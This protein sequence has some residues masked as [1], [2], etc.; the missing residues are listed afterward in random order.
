MEEQVLPEEKLVK[1]RDRQDRNRDRPS[2]AGVQPQ[3]DSQG[4]LEYKEHQSSGLEA[5]E[6]GFCCPISHSLVLGGG[7]GGVRGLGMSIPG[8]LQ[9]RQHP[10]ARI[11]LQEHCLWSQQPQDSQL[12]FWAGN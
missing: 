8:P 11:I 7:Q 10:S 6:P 4:A 9:V 1:E 2:K 3:P 12:G 5:R